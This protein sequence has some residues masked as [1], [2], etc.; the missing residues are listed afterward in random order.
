M[1]LPL[2]S[3]GAAHGLG[4]LGF[5]RELLKLDAVS[6]GIEEVEDARA[7]NS[8]TNSAFRVHW[9]VSF[10]WKRRQVFP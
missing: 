8:K 10:G 4:L 5:R 2:L 9:G 6:V 1:S 3:G 7:R